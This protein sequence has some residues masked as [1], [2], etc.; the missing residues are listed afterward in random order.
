MK[1]FSPKTFKTLVTG[2]LSTRPVW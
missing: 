1:Y 2:V